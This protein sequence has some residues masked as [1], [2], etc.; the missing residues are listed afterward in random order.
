MRFKLPL[1]LEEENR[2]PEEVALALRLRRTSV[3]I[4]EQHLPTLDL[5][6]TSL[7]LELFPHNGK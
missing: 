5:Q 2:K 1:R 7:N 4:L 3:T 6:N